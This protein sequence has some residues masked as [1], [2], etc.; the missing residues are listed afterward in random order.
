MNIS[1]TNIFVN[2]VEKMITLKIFLCF[3]LIYQFSDGFKSTAAGKLKPT[4]LN[5]DEALREKQHNNQ[6]TVDRVLANNEV[7]PHSSFNPVDGNIRNFQNQAFS[8]SIYAVGFQFSIGGR[9]FFYAHNQEDLNKWVIQELLPNGKMGEWTDN[10]EW[11]GEYSFSVAFP[12]LIGGR[13]FFYVQSLTKDPYWFI[14]ELLPGGKMGAETDSGKFGDPYEIGTPFTVGDRQFFYGK[15]VRGYFFIQELLPGG[16]MGSET[17]NGD[18]KSG[19]EGTFAFAID[20]RT[21]FYACNFNGG[22]WTIRELLAGG[23]FGAE[24]ASGHWGI[25]YDVVFPYSISGRAFLYAHSTNDDTPWF[26][27]ELLPGGQLGA[28]T[29]SGTWRNPYF[30]SF[31]FVIN[32]R[33]F[34]YGGQMANLHRWFI[35]ELLPNGKMGAETDS[36]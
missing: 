4:I 17:A 8:N 31:P 35:Q 34:F 23:T 20:G 14:R 2:S 11:P 26:I 30:I 7:R 6:Y 18:I 32:D 10:G 12:F 24:T 33:L 28:A 16:K 21:F 36:G 15:S 13:Q 19:F 27:Q 1:Y 25:D 29:D 5:I 22:Y 9:T 3:C